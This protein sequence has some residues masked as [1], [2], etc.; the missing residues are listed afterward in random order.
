MSTDIKVVARECRFAIHVPERYGKRADTHIVKEQVHYSDGTVKPM[1]RMLQNVERDVYVTRPNKRTYN[2]KREWEA[3]DDLLVKKTTQSKM[4]DVVAKL[5]DKGWSKDYMKKLAQSPYL[6]GTDISSTSLIKKRY[7]DQFPDYNT[8]Y[9]LCTF[10]VETDVVNGTEEVIMASV[11]F[12]NDIFISVKKDFVSGFANLQTLFQNKCQELIGSYLTKNNQKVTLHVADDVVDLIKACFTRIHS[13]KPDWLAIWNMDFDVPKVLA[14]LEKYNVDP[15]DVICD[16]EIPRELRICE[17]KQGPKKKVTASGK[18]MPI[19]P[20]AQWH[21][22]VCTSSFY[23]IDAMCAYKHLRLGDQ[24]ESSYSLDYIL[25]KKL[26]IRKLAFEEAEK[27]S[28]L[29][30]HQFL[31]THFKLEYMVYN[32]FDSLSM[33][34]LDAVTKDL[35]FTLPTFSATSDFSNFKSQP[36]RI[37]DALHFYALEQGYVLGTVGA[38]DDEKE[39]VQEY[40]PDTGEEIESEENVDTVL[41]LRDWILTLPPHHAVL[42]MRC[43]EED[44]SI[45]TGIRG[46]VY[47]SDATA[48]YPSSTSVGNVSKS[49]TKK[50]IISIDGVEEVTFR[51]QNLNLVL[52]HVNALEYCQTMFN[53]PKPEMLLK[54][55]N[56]GN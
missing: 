22:L 39:D 27:Y 51:A 5:L 26:G 33:L 46:F 23:V 29:R 38:K 47:D 8:P 43:I 14:M 28:G 34:E 3:L 9:T 54:L 6:Y 35:A 56:Q 52:G 18:V 42:G 53:M 50:E 30:K 31:Q 15:I 10:D 13:H 16:P 11:I 32:I 2:D 45:Q 12:K 24:E 55:Y 20:A 1:L 48:A 4:R 19:N 21:T 37:T 17:Y 41:D 25:N 44:P 7:Q 36:R 40:D 49:T